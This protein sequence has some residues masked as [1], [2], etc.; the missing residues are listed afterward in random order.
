MKCIS[1]FL[2]FDPFFWPLLSPKKG[3]SSSN[4]SKFSALISELTIG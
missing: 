3:S 4:L 2:A 1:N